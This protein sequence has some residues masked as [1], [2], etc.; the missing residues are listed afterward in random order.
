MFMDTKLNA[1]QH[2]AATLENAVLGVGVKYC[3]WVLRREEK[4]EGFFFFF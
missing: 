1:K 2:S 3:V 4:I